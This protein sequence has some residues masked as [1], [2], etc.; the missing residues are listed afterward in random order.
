MI[1]YIKIVK[2]MNGESIKEQI[3]KIIDNGMM[4]ANTRL[5]FAKNNCLTCEDISKLVPWFEVVK[6]NDF[7]IDNVVFKPKR[8][9]ISKAEIVMKNKK[10]NA[11]DFTIHNGK[12]YRNGE[13]ITY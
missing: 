8:H 9:M 2:Y 6:D 1:N 7:A 10:N 11:N 4:T 5:F 3:E 12:K 13:E